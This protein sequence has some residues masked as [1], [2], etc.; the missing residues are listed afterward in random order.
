MSEPTRKPDY[1]AMNRQ[2]LRKDLEQYDFVTRTGEP[3]APLLDSLMID[4]L[5]PETAADICEGIEARQFECLAAPFAI[6]TLGSSCV[7]GWA[8]Q[9][10]GDRQLSRMRYTLR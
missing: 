6:P 8:L 10:R 1:G 4:N 9:A 2:E 3:L 7:G 5:D